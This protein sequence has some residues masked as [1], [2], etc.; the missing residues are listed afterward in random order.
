MSYIIYSQENIRIKKITL[1]LFNVFTLKSSKLN[2]SNT[3]KYVF[4]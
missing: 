4:V 2:C 1:K 3:S